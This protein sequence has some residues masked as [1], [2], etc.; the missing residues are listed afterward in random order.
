MVDQVNDRR[1][2]TVCGGME[3]WRAV[4]L[5][6]VL[7][8]PACTADAEGD[9]DGPRA[10]YRSVQ[11]PSDVTRL[12]LAEIECGT[13]TAPLRHEGGEGTV[14]LFVTQFQPEVRSAEDTVL[15]FGGDLGV[16]PDYNLIASNVDALGRDVIMLD[17]RGS[18]RSEPSLGC[19]EVEALPHSPLSEPVDS[20]RTETELLDAI[21][22][23]RARLVAQGVDPSAFDLEEMAADAEDLRVALGIETWNLMAHGT[24]GLIALEYIR[25][26]PEHVRAAVLDSAGWPG[27]DPFATSI[28]G[29]R[30]ATR[31]LVAACAAD[32]LC[33]SIAP[34]LGSDIDRLATRLDERPYEVD[35]AG[36]EVSFDAGWFRVWL[37]ARLSFFR[38]PQTFAP[39]E[40]AKLLEGHEPSVRL[41]AERLVPRQLCQGFFPNCWTDLVRSFGVVQSVMCRNVVAFTDPGDLEGM[42]AG[43]AGYAEAFARSPYLDACDA[44]D[45]GRGH[46]EVATPVTSDVPV[47]VIVGRFDPYGTLAEAERAMAGLANGTLIVSPANGHQVTGT[48]TEPDSC[49]VRIRNRWL[50]APDAS[51]DTSCVDR[52]RLGFEDDVRD[53]IEEGVT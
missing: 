5:V 39:L 37:R 22:A 36:T 53:V 8:L 26:Y 47:L 16:E 25:R 12:V 49:I 38:P 28:E 6:A 3:R 9:D 29:T 46:P 23:C 7:V 27:V 17:A 15:W 14:R 21:A 34:D 11:C 45:A 41:E 1:F 13:L 24:T 19:P 40:I 43:K 33:R 32:R 2:A 48:D 20:D 50:D 51:V 42:A 44:W 35:T 52:L 18:G 10:R 30:H 4:L 31:E